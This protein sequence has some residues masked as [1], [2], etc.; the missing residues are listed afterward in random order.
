MRPTPIK[1]VVAVMDRDPA[2]KYVGILMR[3]NLMYM[4]HFVAKYG[5]PLLAKLKACVKRPL[6][7][8]LDP[9]K[10]GGREAAE[11]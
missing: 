7:L 3:S 10:Y 11:R 6:E 5:S 1:E 8:R 2:V 9:A 4:E